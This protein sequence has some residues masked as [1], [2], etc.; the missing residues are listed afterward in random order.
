MVLRHRA[1][2]RQALDPGV[3]F[4]PAFVFFVVKPFARSDGWR[5][6]SRPL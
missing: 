2:K 6:P 5:D 4:G 1:A 3:F